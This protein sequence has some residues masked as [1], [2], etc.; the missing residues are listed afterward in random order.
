MAAHASHICG[1]QR[2]GIGVAGPAT[3][4]ER[5]DPLGVAEDR[6]SD[7]TLRPLVGLIDRIGVSITTDSTRGFF[8][9]PSGVARRPR[10]GVPPDERATPADARRLPGG[11]EQ[12][13]VGGAFLRARGAMISTSDDNS[14]GDPAPPVTIGCSSLSLNETSAGSFE[15]SSR[16]VSDR[17]SIHREDLRPSS[18]LTER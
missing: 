2:P 16:D 4:A 15:A 3:R 6:L 11:A 18:S 7:P 1:A 14:D 13:V 9:P 17:S 5:R 10:L 12:G 8:R